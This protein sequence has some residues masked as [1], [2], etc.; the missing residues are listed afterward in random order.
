[1][2]LDALILRL[3]LLVIVIVIVVITTFGGVCAVKRFAVKRLI[4][5]E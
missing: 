2:I 3:P 4:R 5:W 1:M